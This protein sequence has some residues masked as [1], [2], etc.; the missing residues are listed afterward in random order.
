[1]QLR[2]EPE[3]H[4]PTRNWLIAK[5]TTLVMRLSRGEASVPSRYSAIQ[6]QTTGRAAHTVAENAL[7]TMA[8]GREVSAATVK[9]KEH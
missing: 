9:D 1:M 4:I 2:R 6:K 3:F 8:T 5:A 7:V